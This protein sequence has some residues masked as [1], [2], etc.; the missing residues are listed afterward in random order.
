MVCNFTYVQQQQSTREIEDLE[1]LSL[2]IDSCLPEL[3]TTEL[4]LTL[5]QLGINTEGKQDIVSNK[6]K[7]IRWIQ[8]AYE[9]HTEDMDEEPE[10]RKTTFEKKTQQDLLFSVEKF[11]GHNTGGGHNI[12]CRKQQEN[13]ARINQKEQQTPKDVI[14]DNGKLSNSYNRI[15]MKLVRQTQVLLL[16]PQV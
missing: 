6:R 14:Y 9:D 5:T 3:G 11:W 7:L 13:N 12:N 4:I 16:L 10:V 8:K 1:K 15:N 2:K